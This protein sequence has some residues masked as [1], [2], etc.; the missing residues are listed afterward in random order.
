M[1]KPYMHTIIGSSGRDCV[2]VILF[3]L[4]GSWARL[5]EGNLFLV[6]QY[7]PQRSSPKTTE[8]ILW[9]LISL[10][11]VASKGK[12]IQKLTKIVKMEVKKFHI[13]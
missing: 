7:Y 11:F 12:R 2:S 5:F 10:V 8:I 3:Q 4:Y 9:M 13:S 6:G 1:K